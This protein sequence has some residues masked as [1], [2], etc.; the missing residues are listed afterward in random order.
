ME[1]CDI[2]A[3]AGGTTTRLIARAIPEAACEAM[4]PWVLGAACAGADPAIFFPGSG[5]HDT[6]ARQL[7]ARCPVKAECREYSL[8]TGPHWGV[9]GGLDESERK[10]IA[11]RRRRQ[12]ARA[13]R[14]LTTRGAA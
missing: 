10:S 8:A 4:G 2:P 6:E 3:G 5:R 13:R 9:W 14:G 7:C 11:R 1:S 12:R